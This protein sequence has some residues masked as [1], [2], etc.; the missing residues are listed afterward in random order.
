M[1]IIAETKTIK[2]Y[3]NYNKNEI[4]FFTIDPSLN[5]TG[6]TIGNLDGPIEII[7]LIYNLKDKNSQKKV[8]YFYNNI[9]NLIKKYNKK[10]IIIF[11]EDF[12]IGSNS[13]GKSY[14]SIGML[15]GSLIPLIKEKNVIVSDPILASKWRSQIGCPQKDK[16]KIKDFIIEK[17]PNNFNK[18]ELT[19]DA[20]ESF[21]IYLY[22]RKILK[23][24]Y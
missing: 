18:K 5:S 6:I 12:Y 8:Y 23:N 13:Y 16:D 17:I 1:K 19:I 9:K 3:K 4:I 21:G 22:V 14:K 7:N 11:C 20:I 24:D 10:I 15:Q 2:K